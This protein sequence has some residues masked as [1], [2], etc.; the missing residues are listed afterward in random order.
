MQFT[1]EKWGNAALILAFLM[2]VGFVCLFLPFQYYRSE[3]ASASYFGSLMGSVLG[4]GALLVGYLYNT[5]LNRQRD[6]EL[7][8]EQLADCAAAILV[9]I[10]LNVLTIRHATKCLEDGL[11]TTTR[12]II[13]L[14]DLISTKVFDDHTI[15]F[16]AC[17]ATIGGDFN[18]QKILPQLNTTRLLSKAVA[19]STPD[20]DGVLSHIQIASFL[21]LTNSAER[22]LEHAYRDIAAIVSKLSGRDVNF[23]GDFSDPSKK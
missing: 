6:K 4:F 7:R 8:R 16:C 13:S 23:L 5:R 1:K 11:I 12:E 19:S 9:E 2:V 17:V 20:I 10:V 22:Q 15:D 14:C 18:F 21:I 3:D